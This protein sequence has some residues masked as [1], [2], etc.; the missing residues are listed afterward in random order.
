MYSGGETALSDFFCKQFYIHFNEQNGFR[1]QSK[2]KHKTFA[3]KKKKKKK[4][5]AHRQ[6]K[7]FICMTTRH[8]HRAQSL[9]A[10]R[11]QDALGHLPS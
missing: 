10:G 4:W 5:R 7:M 9:S 1:P 11:R 2:I 3:K 6:S 8:T